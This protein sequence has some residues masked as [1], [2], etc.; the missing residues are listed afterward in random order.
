[1]LLVEEFST[2]ALERGVEMDVEA[3]LPREA[4]T[5][6]PDLVADRVSELVN[7]DDATHPASV[8]PEK[9]GD[10]PEHDA[11]IIHDAETGRLV[12]ATPAFCELVGYNR[13]TVLELGTDGLD[14]GGDGTTR[15]RA[16]AVVTALRATGRV[17]PFEWAVRTADGEQ[18]RLEVTPT[19]ATAPLGGA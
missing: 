17:E 15:P 16:D 1:M 6:A 8:R 9:H 4:V 19:R 5:D 14:A 3:F 2:T 18:R 11:I 7:G 12:D 13:E 10:P